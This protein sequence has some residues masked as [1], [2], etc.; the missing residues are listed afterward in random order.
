MSP[1]LAVPLW[2]AAGAAAG[3]GVRLA[4]ARLAQA[5][6]LVPG[7]RPWQVYGPPAVAAAL[8]GVFA[9]FLAAQP[10]QLLV[11]SIFVLV[12]VQ[13]IF[14]DLEHLL[15]LDRVI[16][17]ALALAFV[18]SL[19]RHPWWAGLATGLAIGGC[20]FLIGLAGTFIFKA[21]A[22]GF[23]DVK[24]ATLV[25]VL[26]GPVTAVESLL[27][28]FFIAGLFAIAIAVMQRSMKGN[29][30]LGPFLAAAGVVGLLNPF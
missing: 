10:L 29:L 30:A 21:D 26:L 4:S 12:M 7:R 25:G 14:F 15:I 18:V 9:Y 20:L 3:W 13:V 6:D 16:L 11:D 27:L 1:I 5:E 24:L 17:P 8:F 28:A 23:G 22:L 19:L 2:T